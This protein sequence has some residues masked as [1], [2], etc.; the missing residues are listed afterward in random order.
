RTASPAPATLP[1]PPG[2]TIAREAQETRAAE[3]P[4]PATVN[5]DYGRE[6]QLPSEI[7]P[8]APRETVGAAAGPASRTSKDRATKVAPAPASARPAAAPQSAVAARSAPAGARE[9][10]ETNV[11]VPIKL[12][13]NGT[14]SEILIR[15]VIERQD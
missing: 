12:S 4:A 8:P 14:P 3:A 1:S 6:I 11:V 9:T 2:R 5:L 7:P 10:T 15:I 13:A